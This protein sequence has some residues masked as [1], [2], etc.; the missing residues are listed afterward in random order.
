MDFIPHIEIYPN[1]E[2]GIFDDYDGTQKIATNSYL[3]DGNIIYLMGGTVLCKY[4]ISDGVSPKLLNK[5]DIAS[6]HTGDPTMDFIRKESAHSTAIVDIGDYLVISLRGGGGGVKNMA[7]GVIVGNISI[8]SK[9]TLEKVK[10][11]NFE[12]RVTYITKYKDLLIVSFHFHGFY[13]Y[14][15]S[16]D[17]DIISCIFKH[18]AEEKP[19]TARAIEFQNSEVFEKE[20]GKINIAFAVY[21]YG[22]AVFN[23]DLENNSLSPCC[24]LNPIDIP[25]MYDPESGIKNTVFGLTSKGNFVY[26]GITPGNNRFREKYKD[27]DWNRY[28]N[29]GIIYGPH[30]RLS[31]E[32]YHLELPNID[33]P[34]Y[35][36]VIAGDPSPSF[37]CTVGNLLLFNLDKQGLGIARIENDGK[38]TYVGRALEDRDGRMLTYRIYF[39]GEFLYTSYK[40]PVPSADKPPV[41]RIYKVRS[42]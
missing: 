21:S 24:A 1:Y 4:D 17:A 14:K 25:D 18:I 38:L 22:I 8:I 30:D 19:R 13:I 35:I 27:V 9:E 39:D 20:A 34:E 32:Y 3:R 10:E 41:F 5:A 23:Y 29:R 16:N 7:D 42:T 12:N 33:K 26:G 28:D 37:L 36:G 2:D 15:I 31:G 11:L 40:M 6:D